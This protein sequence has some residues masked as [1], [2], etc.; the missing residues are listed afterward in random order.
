MLNI[1]YLQRNHILIKSSFLANKYAAY[2]LFDIGIYSF[3]FFTHFLVL[4]C[5]LLL[6]NLIKISH[7]DELPKIVNKILF[8]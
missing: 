2:H 1:K 5:L 6:A 7:V 4:I 3:Y 8:F